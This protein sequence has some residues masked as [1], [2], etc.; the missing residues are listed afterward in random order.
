MATFQKQANPSLQNFT[1]DSFLEFEAQHAHHDPSQELQKRQK[2]EGPKPRLGFRLCPG[3]G[4]SGL[5]SGSALCRLQP[6]AQHP[7]TRFQA[8]HQQLQGSVAHRDAEPQRKRSGS[9]PA[10]CSRSLLSLSLSVK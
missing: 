6:E 7:S 4:S 10:P 3:K 8:F 2:A 1:V 5:S 9:L